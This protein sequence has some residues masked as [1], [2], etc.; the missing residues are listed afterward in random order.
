MASTCP[1]VTVSPAF[2]STAVT[3]PSVAK[4][5]GTLACEAAL[6]LPVTVA[7]T[8]PR[9]TTAVR[10]GAA[11]VL[12]FPITVKAS[13]TATTSS[14]AS[15]PLIHGVRRPPANS[16]LHGRPRRAMRSSSPRSPAARRIARQP[17]YEL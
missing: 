4:L 14:A 1:A 2:T 11:G 13:T 3:V 12:G 6:P 8:S 17:V 7:V 5:A 9:V 15:P 10:T 16:V